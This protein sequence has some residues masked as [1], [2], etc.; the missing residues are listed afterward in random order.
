MVYEE[1]Q[2]RERIKMLIHRESIS[3]REFATKLGR[4]PSNVSQILTGE[5]HVPRGFIADIIK[6][7]PHIRKD[8]VIFGDGTMVDGEEKL[9]DILHEDTKPRLPKS[10]S[11][12]RITEYYDGE[13]RVECQEQDIVKQFTDY[14]FSMILKTNHMSPNYVRGDE[15][16]FKR[17]TVIEWG[18]EYLIDT[19][20]GPK[21]AMIYDDGDCFRCASYNSV[22]YPDFLVPK[23]LVFGYYLLIG[24]QR[25]L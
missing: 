18:H 1:E 5:R 12:G 25:I 24:M 21:F 7:F 11:G 17:R 19:F 8:W 16:Y 6:A 23:N 9:S 3:Q 2:L 4:L 13:K 20:E 10:M 15:L 14:D 22:K